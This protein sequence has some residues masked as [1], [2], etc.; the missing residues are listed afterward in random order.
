MNFN[1]KEFIIGYAKHTKVIIRRGRK[2]PKVKQH[3]SGES[4]TTAEA[5]SANRY[6]FHSFIFEKG[7]VHHIGWY[8]NIHAEDAEAYF[9]LSPKRWIDDELALWWLV[10]IYDPYSKQSCP[11]ET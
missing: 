4:V 1:A 3:R 5:I 7:K 6:I 2:Y 11:G 9:A 8:Q 10:N